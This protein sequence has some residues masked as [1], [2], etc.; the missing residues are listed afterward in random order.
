MAEK[1]LMPRR[2]T[3]SVMQGSAKATTVLMEGELFI[4]LPD[5]GVGNGPTKIKIGDGTTAYSNLPYALGDSVDT[6]AVDF[7]EEKG[8]NMEEILNGVKTGSV[9]TSIVPK[10]KRALSLLM[11]DVHTNYYTK[12]HSDDR[13]YTKAEIDSIIANY[14]TKSET[15]AKSEVYTKKET[16]DLVLIDIVST[17]PTNPEVGQRWVKK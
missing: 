14:Y 11:T 7:I 3:K 8:T 16:K 13:Y 2:G 9:L 17:D 5:A 6:E 1:H 4:E 15:Y 12:T 10:L